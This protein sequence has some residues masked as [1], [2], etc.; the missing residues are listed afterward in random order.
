MIKVLVVDDH[1]LIRTGMSLLLGSF[2]DI[3][4]VGEAADGAEA[5]RQTYQLE[6]DV[7]FLDISMPNGLDGFQIAQEIGQQLP[8]VKI[9]FLT[10]HEEEAYVKKALD[11]GVAG[12]LPKKSNTHN[13]HKAIHDVMLGKLY[14]QTNFSDKL[15]K[16]W[17]NNS[18]KKGALTPRELEILRLFV[19]GFT[20]VEIADKIS[21]APKTVENHRANM[22]KKLD[23]SRRHELIQYGL[24]NQ[25]DMKNL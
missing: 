17:V 24:R 12:Y 5:L 10:M 7:V 3:K 14:Y 1:T 4:V 2:G 9:I 11:L 13:L 22:M 8:A 6:P 15:I 21:I 20:N 23:M 16:S 25:F 19:L 18:N